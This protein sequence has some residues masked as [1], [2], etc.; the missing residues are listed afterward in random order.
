M[1]INKKLQGVLVAGFLAMMISPAG[2]ISSS[3]GV[4]VTDPPRGFPEP[5]TKVPVTLIVVTSAGSA[6]SRPSVR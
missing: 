2:P 5:S 4:N 3:D 6:R 1:K